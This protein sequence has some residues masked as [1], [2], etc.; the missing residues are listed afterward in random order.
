MEIKTL[1]TESSMDQGH[2]CI[3]A[4]TG[5]VHTWTEHHCIWPH[6]SA[7]DADAEGS[8]REVTAARCDNV[9]HID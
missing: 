1:C 9:A 8:T 5:Q 2:N 6:E 7:S 4:H 3:P